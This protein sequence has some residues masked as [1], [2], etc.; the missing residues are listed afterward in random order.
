MVGRI[1]LTLLATVTLSTLTQADT[2]KF[3]KQM[4]PVLEAYLNIQEALASDSLKKVSALA[5]KI[6]KAAAKMDAKTVKGE[7]A[8]HFKDIPANLKQ[9]AAQ[10]ANAKDIESARNH[11]K[12]LSQPMAMWAGMAKPKGIHVVYCSMAK[13][14]WLQKSE[15]IRNPYYG[16]KMLA[17]GDIVK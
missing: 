16:S 17:C 10:L 15:T 11:F 13:G 7:H 6:E 14:S 9:S 3:D 12:K 4:K 5:G 2:S 8:S 1:F